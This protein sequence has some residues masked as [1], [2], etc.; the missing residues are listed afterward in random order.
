MIKFLNCLEGFIYN[1][2]LWGVGGDIAL[3]S[4]QYYKF[5]ETDLF[6]TIWS[7]TVIALILFWMILRGINQHLHL[8]MIRDLEE[9][10][11]YIII[12]R[13]NTHTNDV[14]VLR[15]DNEV[16]TDND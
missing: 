2:W 12:T 14:K 1:V 13:T 11:P 6:F 8:K 4:Y 7:L 5:G 10:K 16:N 15:N 9:N 3:I